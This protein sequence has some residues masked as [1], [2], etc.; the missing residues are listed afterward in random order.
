MSWSNGK[1]QTSYVTNTIDLWKCLV[2]YEYFKKHIAYHWWFDDFVINLSKMIDKFDL[3]MEC[4]NALWDGHSFIRH[5][6]YYETFMRDQTLWFKTPSFIR[7]RHST[8]RHLESPFCHIKEVLMLNFLSFMSRTFKIPPFSLG[9][10][11]GTF[12]YQW[13][14]HDNHGY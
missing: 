4:Q 13:E 11:L 14:L 1:S 7:P 5:P 10:Y 6:R 12:T 8:M 3:W 9:N 2:S